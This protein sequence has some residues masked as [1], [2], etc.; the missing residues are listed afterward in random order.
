MVVNQN[1]PKELLTLYDLGAGSKTE[2][3]EIASYRGLIET[4]EAM[5][6]SE[7]A[8]LLEQNLRQEEEM[9]KKLHELRTE[10]GSKALNR[11]EA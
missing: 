8:S 4:A 10:Y 1:P 2:H 5:G 7:V 3:F 11:P 6:E 9:E